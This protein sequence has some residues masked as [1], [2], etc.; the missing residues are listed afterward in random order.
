MDPTRSSA[1]TARD[2]AV[3]GSRVRALGRTKGSDHGDRAFIDEEEEG[4]EIRD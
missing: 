4:E 1:D 2:I 3:G